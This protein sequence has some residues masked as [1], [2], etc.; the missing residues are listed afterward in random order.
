MKTN[1]LLISQGSTFMVDAIKKNLESVGFVVVK[2]TLTVKDLKQHVDDCEIFLM[3][4]GDYIMDSFDG[5]VFI[6]DICIERDKSLNVI[7][8]VLEFEELKRTI[9]EGLI[10]NSFT[11]PIDVKQMVEVMLEV[12]DKS[13]SDNKKKSILLA[14]DDPTFLK[15]AKEWL[16]E[17]YKVTIVGSGM[18]VITYLAKN[19]PDL[20]LLDYEMPVTTG[21]QVMEMIRSESE[22]SSIPVIFLTGKDDK[23][24]VT[25]V[26]SLKPQGYILKGAGRDNLL[27]QI[28]DFFEIKKNKK[29]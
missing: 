13:N 29:Y 28:S 27:N 6:K 2:S 20:I 21:T 5:L 12:A 19:T 17:D 26:L 14:D 8:D 15:L 18:Q 1:L 11:R 25:K 10:E 22:T 9:P 24:S 3:Y 16:S 23:E 7:G 4:L